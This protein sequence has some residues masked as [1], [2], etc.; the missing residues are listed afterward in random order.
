MPEQF[1]RHGSQV[2]QD[3]AVCEVEIA[4][5]RVAS[6][7]LNASALADRMEARPSRDL[8]EIRERTARVAVLRG[9]AR[10]GQ[11]AIG[12]STAHLAADDDD[13]EPAVKKGGEEGSSA[14]VG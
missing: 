2:G 11:E 12:R 13:W 14:G 3:A 6:L 7:V 1:R 5:Q 8:N 4:V 9:A 10:A